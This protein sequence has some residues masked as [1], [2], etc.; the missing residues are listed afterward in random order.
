[1]ALGM[2]IRKL[3]EGHSHVNYRDSRLTYLLQVK[4]PGGRAGGW[5]ADGRGMAVPASTAALPLLQRPPAQQ[6]V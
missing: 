2:V 6:L 4:T 3:V 1:M 5:R